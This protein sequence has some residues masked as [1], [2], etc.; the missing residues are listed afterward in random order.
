MATYREIKGIT[1]QTRDSDPVIGGVAGASWSSGGSLN[2]A[3]YALK[4][5]GTQTQALAFSGWQ[6]PYSALTEQYDGTSL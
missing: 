5:V 6:P 4:S 3:R 2:T 1:V